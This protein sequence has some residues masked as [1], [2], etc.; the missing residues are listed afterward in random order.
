MKLKNLLSKFECV[1]I[2]IWEQV[3]I[4]KDYM[5]EDV[6]EGDSDDVPWYLADKKIREDDGI[7]AFINED[8]KPW[9]RITLKDTAILEKEE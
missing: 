1:N 3:S 9:I 4:Y 7:A 6:F 5:W 2:I 8:G